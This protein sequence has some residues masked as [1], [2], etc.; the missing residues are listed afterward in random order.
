MGGIVIE[1]K[2]GNVSKN[3]NI[4][5]FKLRFL[6]DKSYL[7][8]NPGQK[9]ISQIIDGFQFISCACL[10]SQGLNTIG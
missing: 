6:C 3:K 1:F 8:P 4:K 2:Q 10:S 7:D 9:I 5:F